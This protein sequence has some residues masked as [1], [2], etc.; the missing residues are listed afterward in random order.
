MLEVNPIE[1]K[2]AKAFELWINAPM[3][4]VTLFKTLSIGNLL[5]VSKRKGLKLNML[6]CWCIGSAASR[7]DEFYLLPVDGR[8]MQFESIAV[9]VVVK[10]KS[11]GINTCDIPFTADVETFNA[12]YLRLTQQVYEADVAHAVGD[13]CMVIGTSALTDCD[14]D[15]AVNIYSGI[16]NNPFVVWGKFRRHLFRTSLPISFQFHHV[17]MDGMEAAQFLNALQAEIDGLSI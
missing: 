1:T 2:R 9:N 6:L 4:M 7:I 17:Q 15:G 14:I 3:P 11:G 13:E 12:N 5:K 16:Y 10:T 8:L